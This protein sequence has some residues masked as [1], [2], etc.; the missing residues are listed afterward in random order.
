M[1]E[2]K[3][4]LKQTQ[5]LLVE[6]LKDYSEWLPKVM[7]ADKPIILECYA[8]W[9]APCKKVGPKLEQYALDNKGKFKLVKLNIDTLP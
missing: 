8:E 7:Q 4:F 2:T 9:C 5:E 3:E 6:E 1:A